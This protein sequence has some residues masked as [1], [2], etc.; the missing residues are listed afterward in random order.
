MEKNWINKYFDTSFCFYFAFSRK[1]KIELEIL[2]DVSKKI[3]E[4]IT[5]REMGERDMRSVAKHKNPWF[6]T[7][8]HLLSYCT[9]TVSKK[10]KKKTVACN[11]K[12]KYINK[13]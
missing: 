6:R 8:S 9:A 5:K 10:K 7:S 11:K 3:L 13:K 12:N 1:K 2:S 4:A